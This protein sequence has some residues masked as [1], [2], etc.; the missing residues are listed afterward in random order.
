[1]ILF[2]TLA[3]RL[4]ITAFLLSGCLSVLLW[5]SLA[6]AQFFKTPDTPPLLE[7]APTFYHVRHDTAGLALGALH[8]ARIVSTTEIDPDERAT[9]RVETMMLSIGFRAN[10]TG[11]PDLRWRAGL[12]NLDIIR[13]PVS[14]GI[15]L[16][17][18]NKSGTK[19]IDA[20]WI[21][22]RI[23]PSLYLGNTRNGFIVRATG[24]A[25]ANSL[26]LGEPFYGK[27]RDIAL[28]RIR[29][30]EVGYLGEAR[31]HLFDRVAV[32][33]LFTHR[34]FLGEF[35]SGPTPSKAKFYQLQG[36]FTVNLNQFIK[37]HFV[38]Y[39]ELTRISGIEQT[40]EGIGGNFE[41]RF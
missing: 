22:L 3:T 10:H 41:F 12:L 37:V 27:F 16:A 28:E 23:G 5:P 11:S 38:Y 31:I 15:T 29:T 34:T 40:L 6:K 36:N 4:R 19:D 25:G 9:G 35:K 14:V 39:M 17:D 20:R 30:Y 32:G 2:P 33:G 7:I 26:L 8:Y 1:M 18:Y 13:S 21:D 24:N